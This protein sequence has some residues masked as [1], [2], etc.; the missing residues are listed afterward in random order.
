M[1]SSINPKLSAY[2][3]THTHTHAQVYINLFTTRFSL[4]LIAE[5]IFLPVRS[6]LQRCK[7]TLTLSVPIQ[8]NNAFPEIGD[9]RMKYVRTYSFVHRDAVNAQKH[10]EIPIAIVQSASTVRLGSA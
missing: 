7:G 9:F 4:I 2:T 6:F 10:A 5:S 8:D 3:H 1:R